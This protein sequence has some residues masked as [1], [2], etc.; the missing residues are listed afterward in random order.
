MNVTSNH[1]KMP[2]QEAT[3][4]YWNQLR[5]VWRDV[6]H[7]F[8]PAT[9]H[10]FRVASR[11]TF[12]ALLLLESVAEIDGPSK[13]RRRIKRLTKQLGPLRDV[14]VQI[15]L[16]EEWKLSGASQGFL[17]T[18]KLLETRERKR[19]RRFLT[20]DRKQ[21][22]QR[23]LKA[24]DRD[25][26]E[27]LKRRP[28]KAIQ[29][30]V[31]I[32]LNTQRRALRV[33]HENRSTDSQSLHRLRTAARKL[34]YCLEAAVSTVGPAP[35]AEIQRLRRYQTELGRQRDLQ[36]VKDEFEQ[37]CR[38]EGEEIPFSAAGLSLPS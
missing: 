20:A 31:K 21:K 2:L 5:K 29:A 35:R 17:E 16:V 1:K 26:A 9:V 19:V 13:A 12:S 10:D 15:S 22:I 33:A 27:R 14:Q 3:W 6:R 36:I 25:I 38:K 28:A 8:K 23:S 37:W 7:G 4:E 18:L 24:F 32:A 11:R 34:R 30:E